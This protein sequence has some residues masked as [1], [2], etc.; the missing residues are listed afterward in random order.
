MKNINELALNKTDAIQINPN[1]GII[2]THDMKGWFLERYVNIFMNGVVVDYVDNVN[3]AGLIN[4]YRNYTYNEIRTVDI[5][6]VIER[7]IDSENYLHIW[8][9]EYEIPYSIRYKKHHFIH[10][11]MVY[12]YNR[13]DRKIKAVFFDIMRGQSFVEINY[14]SI[15]DAVRNIGE[16]CCDGGDDTAYN[17]TIVSCKPSMYMKGTFHLDYFVEQLKNYACC[18]TDAGMEWYA[19]ARSGLFDSNSTIYGIQIYKQIINYL[20]LPEIR[21]HLEYKMLHDFV[22]HK[23]LL[24]ERFNFISTIFT[25]SQKFVKLL[26]RF[27]SN[28][29]A[30]ERMRLLNIKKQI[31]KGSMPAT[32]CLDSEFISSLIEVLKSCY[33]TEMEIIPKILDE[34]MFLAH[35]N[36]HFNRKE[37]VFLKKEDGTVHDAYVEYDFKSSDIYAY[38]IDIIRSGECVEYSGFESVVINNDLKLYLERDYTGH[39]PIRTVWFPTSKLNTLRIHTNVKKSDYTM[40]IWTISPETDAEHVDIALDNC[41]GG[42]HHMERLPFQTTHTLHLHIINEDP[43]LVREHLAVLA[44]KYPY[45]HIRMSSTVNTIYAQVFFAT[46]ENSSISADK[47]LFFRINPDGQRHSYYIRMSNN[48]LWKGVVQTVRFDPAQYHG[49]YTWDEKEPNTCWIERI[50]F[51]KTMPTQCIECNVASLLQEDED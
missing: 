40:H 20:Q 2:L 48:P 34:L 27:K 35:P 39:L 43:F 41:W 17:S 19:L 22:V 33:A 14:S 9:D 32:L 12:G 30:L 5:I 7:E 51:V 13:I 25:T 8:V 10:P 1:L 21:V 44:D 31:K 18:T 28:Y 11:I 15:G 4:C 3:Y 47:S 37:I 16:Y 50:E 36:D 6:N 45:L 26:E 42:Y 24:L 49:T 29:E 38:K 23:K 46:M